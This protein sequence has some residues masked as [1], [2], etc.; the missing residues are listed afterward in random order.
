MLQSEEAFIKRQKRRLINN[1]L[2]AVV[3][4]PALCIGFSIL[5]QIILPFILTDR[6]GGESSPAL[7]PAIL[8]L[9]AIAL[10]LFFVLA[11]AWFIL[12]SRM[13]AID[14]IF[15]SLGLESGAY[16]LFGR[17]YFGSSAGRVVNIFIHWGPT[18]EMAMA[19]SVRPRLK[20]VEHA[21][22]QT[23]KTK[24]LLEKPLALNNKA[25]SKYAVFSS[26]ADWAIDLLDS[27][28][29]A[30]AVQTLMTHG[31]GWAVSRMVEIRPGEVLLRLYRSRKWP[32]SPLEL[33]EVRIWLAKLKT[34]AEEAEQIS[35]K[36]G[37]SQPAESAAGRTHQ[38]LK[39]YQSA[40]II[41][42]VFGVLVCIIAAGII[43]YFFF[44][45]L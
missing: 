44:I 3:G 41:A 22:N 37:V 42:A 24:S 23:T 20:V 12:H 35:L 10:L 25:L 6:S 27:F 40:A 29:A 39:S 8:V 18:I 9:A 1:C 31:A 13:R 43:A 17:Q 34:L 36:R 32:N 11:A 45:N 15:E 5:L 38:N 16:M 28:Q 21:F 14:T 2:V 33:A 19:A 30:D 7:S 26:N 4:G